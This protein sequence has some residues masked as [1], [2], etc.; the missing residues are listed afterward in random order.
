MKP[1]VYFTRK[2]EP[3][4]VL[5]LYRLTGKELEGKVAVKLHS[6]EEAQSEFPE[7]G[8]FQTNDRVCK[9][10]CSRMQYSV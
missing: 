4:K 1:K 6:G 7:T 8:I 9:R 10:G 3:E 2:I 5:E